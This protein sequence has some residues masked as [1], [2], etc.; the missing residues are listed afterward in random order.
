MDSESSTQT[1]GAATSLHQK[2]GRVTVLVLSDWFE[3]FQDRGACWSK[4][5]YKM[6]MMR[7]SR[8]FRIPAEGLSIACRWSALKP[9]RCW[10]YPGAPYLI[11]MPCCGLGAYFG[12]T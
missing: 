1:S 4:T 10:A 12:L 7:V 6:S 9:D 8:A 3:V 2:T 11:R 5:A